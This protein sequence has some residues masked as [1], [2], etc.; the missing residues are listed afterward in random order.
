MRAYTITQTITL[1]TVTSPPTQGVPES[2]L[3]KFYYERLANLI[4][5]HIVTS[6]E[7]AIQDCESVLEGD[8]KDSRAEFCQNFWAQFNNSLRSISRMTRYLVR[9][10]YNI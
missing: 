6:M 2:A 3:A 7:S 1:P 9:T 4:S 10:S 8:S 5:T